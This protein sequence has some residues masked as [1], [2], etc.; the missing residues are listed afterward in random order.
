MVQFLSLYVELSFLIP[1]T[2]PC[3]ETSKMDYVKEK[4]V[5]ERAET[6]IAVGGDGDC[7]RK[8]GVLKLRR[9][10]LLQIF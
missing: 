6:V 3:I 7:G 9:K 8:G 4:E 10:L 2:Q 5:E 1:P